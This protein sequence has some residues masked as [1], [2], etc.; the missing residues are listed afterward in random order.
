MERWFGGEVGVAR[1]DG[2]AAAIPACWRYMYCGD[3]AKV[4]HGSARFGTLR[5]ASARFAKLTWTIFCVLNDGPTAKRLILKNLTLNGDM[6]RSA[7]W[8]VGRAWWG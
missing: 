7:G 6:L 4:R 2:G 1:R 3:E 5:H 8:V